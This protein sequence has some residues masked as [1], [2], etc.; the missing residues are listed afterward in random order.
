MA[1]IKKRARQT[2]WLVKHIGTGVIAVLYLC[3]AAFLATAI[4]MGMFITVGL[5]IEAI[6]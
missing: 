1:E 6:L 3:L 2:V 5:L 4:I